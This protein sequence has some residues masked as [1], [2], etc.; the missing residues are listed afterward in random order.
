MAGLVIINNLLKGLSCS[1]NIDLL[2]KYKQVVVDE[3]I[4]D[5]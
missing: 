5:Y 2:M 4:N 1:I 3:S